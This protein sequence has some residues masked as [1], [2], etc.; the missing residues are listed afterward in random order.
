MKKNNWGKHPKVVLTALGKHENPELPDVFYLSYAGCSYQIWRPVR[1]EQER[2][3]RLRPES[4]EERY[5]LHFYTHMVNS[6]YFPAG[7]SCENLIGLIT[8]DL[9]PKLEPRLGEL[10]TKTDLGLLIL[11][12][13]L[14]LNDAAALDK[15][16]IAAGELTL[17]V[18]WQ[19][20]FTFMPE[21]WQALLADASGS[22]LEFQT[23]CRRRVLAKYFPKVLDVHKIRSWISGFLPEDNRLTQALRIIFLKNWF[24]HSPFPH[25]NEKTVL[26]L[27]CQ[28]FDNSKRTGQPIFEKLDPLPRLPIRGSAMLYLNSRFRAEDQRVYEEG[29]ENMRLYLQEQER[30]REARRLEFEEDEPVYANVEPVVEEEAV[31]PEPQLPAPQIVAQIPAHVLQHEAELAAQMDELLIQPVAEREEPDDSDEGAEDDEALAELDRREVEESLERIAEHQIHFS[32]RRT[33]RFRRR[34]FEPRMVQIVESEEAAP[35][36]DPENEF[37]FRFWFPHGEYDFLFNSEEEFSEF[38]PATRNA[39]RQ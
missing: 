29:R 26:D 11:A 32:Q 20:R 10:R 34:H 14:E 24:E 16:T 36:P 21:Q 30:R 38:G 9:Y 28:Y 33:R 15:L 19:K 12:L 2:E 35:L 1:R 13:A 37:N 22:V 4:Y 3:F 39:V 17:N 7:V 18:N 31:L 5:E 8:V 25:P 27:F 6:S 23:D